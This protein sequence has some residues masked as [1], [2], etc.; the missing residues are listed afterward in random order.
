MPQSAPREGQRKMGRC[1]TGNRDKIELCQG[2]LPRRL[3][4]LSMFGVAARVHEHDAAVRRPGSAPAWN[5]LNRL[6]N[7]V[8]DVDLAAVSLH[9][10]PY[11]RHATFWL[12]PTA[13]YRLVR[14][15]ASSLLK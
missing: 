7:N 5:C 6:R 14:Q 4:S 9:F 3:A 1:L 2:L 10:M 13:E 8:D 11:T 15:Q 12:R